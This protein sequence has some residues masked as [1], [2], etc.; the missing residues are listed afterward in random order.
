MNVRDILKPKSK[1]D[2]Q[3]S[4]DDLRKSLLNLIECDKKYVVIGEWI[5]N[6]L[7]EWEPLT[8]EPVT[9]VIAERIKLKATKAKWLSN[10]KHQEY[11]IPWERY[12]DRY[13]KR[14][15]ENEEI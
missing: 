9:I 13:I 12:V 11:I 3:K 14:V 8:R 15:I 7:E 1:E 10:I 4:I 5:E 2:I 6:G